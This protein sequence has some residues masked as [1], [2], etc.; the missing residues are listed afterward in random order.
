MS[1]PK[2]LGPL[3][4]HLLGR[5]GANLGACCAHHPLL[6][7][8]RHKER[9]AIDRDLKV[10][11]TRRG[12]MRSRRLLGRHDSSATQPHASRSALNL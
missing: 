11:G 8:R 4:L 1:N 7:L 6:R 9:G 3:L 5:A 10:I 12:L 2:A